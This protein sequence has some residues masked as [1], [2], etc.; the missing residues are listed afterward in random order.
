MLNA[1]ALSELLSQNSDN[2]LCKRWLIFTPKGTLLAYSETS[3]IRDLRRQAAKAALLWQEQLESRHGMSAID[4]K[5]Q[6]ASPPPGLTT[7]TIETESGNTIIRQIQPQLL[8]V[9]EGG[10]PPRKRTF[11]PRVTPEG[12]GDVPYPKMV[13]TQPQDSQPGSFVSSAAQSVKSNASRSILAL[14]R[15]KLDA[16]AAAIAEDFDKTDF[17]MPEE[18]NAKVF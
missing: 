17:R 4:G 15:R 6:R 13:G 7:L 1:K 11:E 3:S 12:P 2:R 18:G 9:L 14:Q 5:Q 10:V 16:L 8:L